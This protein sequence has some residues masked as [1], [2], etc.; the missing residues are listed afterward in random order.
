MADPHGNTRLRRSSIDAAIRTVTGLCFYEMAA[1]IRLIVV[2]R[3]QSC[4][5]VRSVRVGHTK[6]ATARRTVL[7]NCISFAV[8]FTQSLVLFCLFSLFPAQAQN[9]PAGHSAAI[10][11]FP[12]VLAP[13]D[14][15]V[16]GAG[17]ANFNKPPS[18]FQANLDLSQ[19]NLPVLRQAGQEIFNVHMVTP[20]LLRGGQPSLQGLTLLKQAGVKTVI[21]L[22]NEEMVVSQEAAQT[23]S[24]GLNYVSIPMDVFNRPSDAAV[25][26]FLT[27]VSDPNNQPVYVH[28]LHGQDRT[29]TMCGIYRMTQQGWP[30]DAT[31]NE[32]V[33]Y[34]FKPLLGQLRQTVIDYSHRGLIDVTQPQPTFALQEIKSKVGNLLHK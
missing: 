28:C 16:N 18:N 19:W 11:N 21:N 15:A 30:L 22:R 3:Q 29:G 32:M 2:D 26:Q 34:G 8:L 14:F 10:Q 13:S 17:R 20:G 7:R 6:A 12:A 31:Y 5:L 33:A 25:R 27:A 4:C 1:G 9:F 24:L 23:R